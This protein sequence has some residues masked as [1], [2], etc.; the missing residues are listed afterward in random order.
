VAD[1]LFRTV[2][3]AGEQPYRTGSFGTQCTLC[4]R[5]SY[6]WTMPGIF[7]GAHPPPQECQGWR[8]LSRGFSR[9]EPSFE[10]VAPIA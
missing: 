2:V 1:A 6:L 5:V 3:A 10:M 8:A 4:S 9:R 7:K